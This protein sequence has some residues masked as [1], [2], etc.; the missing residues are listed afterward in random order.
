MARVNHDEIERDDEYEVEVVCPVCG[1]HFG[2]SPRQANG[3]KAP[4]CGD[5]CEQQWP[6]ECERQWRTREAEMN[7]RA[8]YDYACGYHD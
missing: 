4:C 1:E 6:Q 3:E 5:D 2:C 8:G 7:Y